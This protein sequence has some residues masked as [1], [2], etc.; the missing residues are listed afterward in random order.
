MS[1]PS[2]G[3]VALRSEVQRQIQLPLYKAWQISLKSIRM[4]F[5]RSVIT[6][7]GILL[8]IAFY[9]SVRTSGLFPNHG[10]SAEALAAA[11][12]QE[13]L[14]VMAL[15]VCFVGI[16]NSMLMSVTE[17]FKEIGTMKCL[18]ALDSFIVRL[19]II[20]AALMGFIASVLGWF[21]GWAIIILVHLIGTGFSIFTVALLRNSLREAL[22][23]TALGS[24]ITLVAAVP[25][26]MRAAQMPPAAA[27]RTEV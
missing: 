12:R 8:G 9:S 4:R 24:I 1:A 11:H 5:A 27:L 15:L 7:M 23:T 13:W 18:G 26:A 6:A 16:I 25:P 2:Q 17:R 21:A 14:A 22:I 19:V 20:E 3:T 10:T